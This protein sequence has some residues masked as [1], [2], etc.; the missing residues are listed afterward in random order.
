MC[1]YFR[2]PIRNTTHKLPKSPGYLKEPTK[3]RLDVMRRTWNKAPENQKS[4]VTKRQMVELK[5]ALRHFQ[6]V[7]NGVAWSQND[8]IR[9]WIAWLLHHPEAVDKIKAFA[10]E[11]KNGGISWQ[12]TL[13]I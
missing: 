4:E 1:Y 5:K 3:F 6:T 11:I 10:A 7:E 8:P 12:H 13:I 9:G 2:S